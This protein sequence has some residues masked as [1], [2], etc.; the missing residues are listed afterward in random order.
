MTQ[1]NHHER[2]F[3]AFLAGEESELARLYRRLPQAE[4]DAK[5]DA[6]VL[7][8]ARTAVEPQRVNAL[9]HA[10]QRHRRPWWLVGLSSAAGLVLAAGIAWQMQ[11]MQQG[12]AEA[13][14]APASTAQ[15]ERDVIPITA[16]TT[17]EPLPA[18]ALPPAEAAV[19][20]ANLA[21]SPPA[22]PPPAASMP[23]P[24]PPSPPAA[25][26]RSRAST[27]PLRR[28]VEVVKA[29][30]LSKGETAEFEAAAAV[31]AA[32]PMPVDQALDARLLE[33]QAQSADKRELAKAKDAAS[34]QQPEPFADRE[35]RDYNSVERKA[36]LASGSRRDEYGLNA[37]DDGKVQPAAAKP[38]A[39]A[40]RPAAE[41]AAAGAGS[42]NRSAALQRNAKLAPADW[43]I[44]I[45]SLLRDNQR[46]EALENLD[47]FKRKHPQF[48]LPQ[49]LRDLR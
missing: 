13:L 23:A 12:P 26:A 5:L 40:P 9:R 39:R 46:E 36:A 45:R 4:P 49:D 20:S 47:L 14:R 31:T 30:E 37:G 34:P 42:M 24:P 29:D 41:S 21:A 28:S 22:T 44:A 10:N 7:N 25:A 6:A 11:G 8:L 48:A 35:V 18:V 1:R 27:A 19:A 32:K 16:I 33:A 15:A 38:A 17:P 3:E 2:E 43:V